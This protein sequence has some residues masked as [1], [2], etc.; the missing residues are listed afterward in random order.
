MQI[1]MSIKK[2]L[3]YSVFFFFSRNVVYRGEIAFV[4]RENMKNIQ[5]TNFVIVLGGGGG[6]G[7]ELKPWGGGGGGI[8]YPKGPEKNTGVT[9]SPTSIEYAN[10]IWDT[11]RL[12]SCRECAKNSLAGCI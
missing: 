4:G 12:R 6:G 7:G 1:Q 9:C 2:T 8:S 3:C 5:K 10:R 11:Q